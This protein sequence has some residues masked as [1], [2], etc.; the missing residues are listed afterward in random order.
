[1]ID[2]DE[3]ISDESSEYYPSSDCESKL[4]LIGSNENLSDTD[5][6]SHEDKETENK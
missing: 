3:D 6:T 2:P 1:L 4:S 5:L